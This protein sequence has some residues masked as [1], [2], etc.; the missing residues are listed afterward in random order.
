M[1]AVY[2]SVDNIIL[3]I[4]APDAEELPAAEQPALFIATSSYK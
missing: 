4:D 1:L 3:V 2:F